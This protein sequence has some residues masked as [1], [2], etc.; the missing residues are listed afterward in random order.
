M[1]NNNNNNK[2]LNIFSFKTKSP[3]TVRKIILPK[4]LI[5]FKINFL[6]SLFARVGNGSDSIQRSMREKWK[7]ENRNE[8]CS[9]LCHWAHA[10]FYL[11]SVDLH[12]PTSSLCSLQ[13]GPGKAGTNQ[14]FISDS[15]S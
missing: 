14:N 5:P 10:I 9:H 1:G 11:R 3:Y 6:L 7:Q 13:L 15:I 4:M 12:E 8:C 2:R